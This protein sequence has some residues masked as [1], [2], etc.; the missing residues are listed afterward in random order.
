MYLAIRRWQGLV[1]SEGRPFVI[2]HF[3]ACV[4]VVFMFQLQGFNPNLLDI[5]FIILCAM[6]IIDCLC[7]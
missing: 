3:K 7:G 1:V 5:A 2:S 6:D 4:F